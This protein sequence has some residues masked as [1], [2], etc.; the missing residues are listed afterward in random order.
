MRLTSRSRLALT[1]RIMGLILYLKVVTMIVLGY[2][3]YFP[4]DFSSNF[5]LGR[6]S[7]FHGIYSCAFYAHILSGPVILLLGLLLLS[8]RFRVASP[9]LHRLMGK[10]QGG[11]II[12]LLAPS[13]LLM[14]LHADGGPVAVTGFVTLAIATVAATLLGWRA[15]VQRRMADHERWMYRC[16]AL[17]LSAV[18]ARLLGGVAIVTQADE[19]WTYPITAWASW[20]LPLAAMEVA[21]LW[22]G[23]RREILLQTPQSI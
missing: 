2:G 7:Y 6:H 13:G 9:A 4:A 18:V 21:F 14:A 3:D 19:T 11:L 5:L 12:L 8:R 10:F 23:N 1:I 16:F 22:Q 17:L 20:L 15:A